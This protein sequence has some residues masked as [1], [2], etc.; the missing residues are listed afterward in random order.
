MIE[1][2]NGHGPHIGDPCPREACNGLLKV[3]STKVLLTEKVRIRFLH[4]RCCK[5]RPERNQE[6]IPLEYAPPQQTRIVI[7]KKPAV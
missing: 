1:L 4:C 6:V 5:S 7:R 3:Y 2:T